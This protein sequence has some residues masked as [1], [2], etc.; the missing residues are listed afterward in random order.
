MSTA[1]GG[2][3]GA[4]W[5]QV[6]ASLDW[7][8]AH[9]LVTSVLRHLSRST[10]DPKWWVSTGSD[11]NEC[12]MLGD[13]WS[14]LIELERIGQWYRPFIT[15]RVLRQIQSSKS[16]QK[17]M[18][19]RAC[20]DGRLSSHSIDRERFGQWYCS[21]ITYPVMP[22]IQ[23][24]ECLQKAMQMRVCVMGRDGKSHLIDLDCIG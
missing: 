4:W 6:V 2:D 14:H 24:S 18:W 15:Y 19:M 11:G 5:R 3:E 12:V 22:K 8:W 13:G 7:P 21:F 16:L 9:R 23:S 1:S 10:L 20:D 17:M